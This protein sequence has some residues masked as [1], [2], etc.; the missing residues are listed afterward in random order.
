MSKV[1][2]LW[3]SMFGTAE[4]VAVDVYKSTKD[5]LDVDVE[6]NEMNDVD[7]DSFKNMENVIF[8]S[9][10]TGQG[11]V[12][13]NGEAFFDKLSGADIDL[14]KTKYGVCALGDSS[15]TYYCG[16]GKKIDK[17]MEELGANRIADRHECDGDDEGAREYSISTIKK[18]IG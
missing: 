13:S 2:I 1:N 18:L 17:R 15:H 4:D 8:I 10:T 6:I 11:D 16:A 5:S 3:A 9:S 12:P 7:M 14:S